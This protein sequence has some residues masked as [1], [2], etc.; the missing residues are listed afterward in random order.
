MGEPDHASAYMLGLRRVWRRES[1]VRAVTAE[2][3]NGR[4]AHLVRVRPQNVAARSQLRHRRAHV[5]RPAPRLVGTGRWWGHG[6]VVQLPSRLRARGTSPWKSGRAR[7]TW[8]AGRGTASS[9]VASC[10][11]LA[12]AGRGAMGRTACCSRW[13]WATARPERTTSLSQ[14]CCHG[15]LRT[16]NLSRTP[17]AGERSKPGFPVVA[18]QSSMVASHWAC[19]RVAPVGWSV[20]SGSCLA[21]QHP[22]CL[23]LVPNRSRPRVQ[24]PR[25]TA[26]WS[27]SA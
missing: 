12:R 8:K 25:H 22:R 5:P 7:R 17:H 3:A 24:K 6:S 9:M 2:H 16:V 26:W 27:R 14:L 18:S 11:A 20:R 10:S 13:K 15:R 21:W 4:I 19:G 23:V 1:D